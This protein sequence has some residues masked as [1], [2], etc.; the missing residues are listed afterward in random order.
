MGFKK[1]EQVVCPNCE[2]EMEVQWEVK[3]KFPK[4]VYWFSGIIFFGACLLYL[5]I[6]LFD[7]WPN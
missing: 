7:E 4:W 5:Y 3:D 1:K 2:Y 6:E